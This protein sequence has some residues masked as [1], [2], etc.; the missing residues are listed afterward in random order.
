MQEQD[1]IVR[2]LSFNDFDKRRAEVFDRV[3]QGGEAFILKR[4]NRPVA[5]LVPVPEAFGP[6]LL[7]AD[8]ILGIDDLGNDDLGINYNFE[9]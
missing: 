1:L 8:E 9:G 6:A 2:T 3:L 7:R 5:M 4:Y